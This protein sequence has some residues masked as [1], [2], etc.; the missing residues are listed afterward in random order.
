MN[1]SNGLGW[2]SLYRQVKLHNHNYY[3]YIKQ[4]ELVPHTGLTSSHTGL[5]G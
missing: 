2:L 3:I 5:T 4:V 1:V